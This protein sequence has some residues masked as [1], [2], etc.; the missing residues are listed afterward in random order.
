[1]SID[2]SRHPTASVGS[3][4]PRIEAAIERALASLDQPGV[5]PRLR[6]ATRH[7][8][9]P[10]GGRLRPHLALSVARAC[11]DRHP[12]LAD[13]VAAAVELL[14]CASLVHDDLPVF[15]DA[16]IR[17]GRPSVHAAF[18]DAQAVLVGDG[19][20]VLAFET[21]ASA[22]AGSNQ[23]AEVVAA[24]A[25]GVGPCRGLVAGQAWESEPEP[26]LAAYH[27]AKTAAL[28][29]AATEAGAIASG[30]V[31]S[32]WR[33]LGELLGAAYQLADDIADHCGDPAALG[34]PVRQDAARG[35][36]NA[37]HA[38][39]ADAAE[40]RL[41]ATLTAACEAI[42]PCPSAPELER[43]IKRSMR[44]LLPARVNGDDQLPV[45]G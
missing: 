34:K 20:I 23:L 35:R 11:G 18:G 2:P 19:L 5:P 36:P 3:L 15:D 33:P 12:A 14:H 17:R 30:G 21:L 16:A 8:V 42:P 7:A 32:A 10:G 1:M 9:F 6:A 45:A 43:W 29:A 37:H 40:Q 39:G 26:D 28:F 31:G 22:G 41:A 38:L 44:R 13:A 27:H 24:I 25:R 4:Q